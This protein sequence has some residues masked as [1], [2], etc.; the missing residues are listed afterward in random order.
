[1]ST[2]WRRRE[3]NPR[4]VPPK[5]RVLIWLY[6]AN[7]PRVRTEVRT[8]KTTEPDQKTTPRRGT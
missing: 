3:S 6:K 7:P 2:I 8:L 4:K 1:M 5:N